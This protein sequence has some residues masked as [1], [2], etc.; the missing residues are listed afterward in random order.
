MRPQMYGL[1]NSIVIKYEDNYDDIN[2]EED[3]RRQSFPATE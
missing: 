3:R 2:L 1:K